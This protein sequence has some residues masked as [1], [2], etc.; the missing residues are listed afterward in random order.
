MGRHLTY[1]FCKDGLCGV[2]EASRAVYP[3]S[4]LQR[5]IVHQ[6]RSSTRFVS[7]KDIKQVAVDLKKIYTSVTLEDAEEA[8]LQFSEEWKK[9]YPSCVKN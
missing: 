3:K 1:L 4:R 5:C 9:R 8:L 6:I 7:W 2:M